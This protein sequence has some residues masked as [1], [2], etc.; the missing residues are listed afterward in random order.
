MEMGM[1][2]SRLGPAKNRGWQRNIA[3]WKQGAIN[4]EQQ[5]LD[6]SAK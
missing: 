3:A 5:S 2:L 6:A 1:A 4:V